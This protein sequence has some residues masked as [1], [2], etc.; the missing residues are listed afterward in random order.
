MKNLLK[1]VLV[2][3]ALG[4]IC[5]YLFIPSKIRFTKIAFI[6]TNQNIATRYL[7]DETNWKKWWPLRKQDSSSAAKVNDKERYTYKKHSYSINNKMIDAAG[8]SIKNSN[9]VLNSNINV[10]ASKKNLI[11]RNIKFND[12]F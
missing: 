6:K 3:S 12:L 11:N 7:I 5:I 9:A 8:I 1:I 2:L 10:I 4:L